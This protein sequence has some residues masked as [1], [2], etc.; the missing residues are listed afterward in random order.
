[1]VRN[2]GRTEFERAT[3]VAHAVLAVAEQFDDPGPVGLGQ[4]LERPEIRR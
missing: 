4:C 2:E 3:H 1:M